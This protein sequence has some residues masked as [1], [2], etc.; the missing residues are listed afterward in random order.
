MLI[1]TL[2]LPRGCCSGGCC[3]VFSII[4]DG[5]KAQALHLL[6]ALSLQLLMLLMVMALL[7]VER[8]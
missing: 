2:M 5:G 6:M 1:L 3:T 4:G 8:C 7:Q